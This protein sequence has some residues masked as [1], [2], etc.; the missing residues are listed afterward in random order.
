[1]KDTIKIIEYGN[2]YAEKAKDL[3]VELQTYLANLDKRGVIVIKDNYREDY[4]SYIS[5]EI[6][7]HQGK[8]FLAKQCDK[9]IGM[10]VCKIFQGG[11]EENLT[12]NCP[13]IGFIS[14]LVVTKSQRGQ[15]IGKLLLSQAEWYFKEEAC[16]YAQL[17][18]FAPNVNAFKL[19]EKSGFQTNCLYLS[20]K[21]S[22]EK[23]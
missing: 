6:K 17:E 7:E 11:E 20:K 14:D 18:V 16:D 9:I 15:G 5:K 4:F 1:M 2:M 23:Y 3:L 12:T 19:Y 22:Y 13:K 21:L 8:I 10:I